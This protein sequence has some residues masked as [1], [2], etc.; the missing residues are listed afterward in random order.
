MFVFTPTEWSSRVFWHQAMRQTLT[1]SAR[2]V[3]Y[4]VLRLRRG[5][6]TGRY[7]F[8]FFTFLLSGLMHVC[9]DMAAGIP[10]AVSGVVQFF[11]IQALGIM[12]EDAVQHMWGRAS[13]SSG[14]SHDGKRKGAKGEDG[15]ELWKRVVGYVWVAVWMAWSVPVWSY[16]AA[17]RSSG[18]GVLPMSLIEHFR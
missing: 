2:F 5:G 17:R 15:P 9:G 10:F 16:P 8:T 11:A 12:I 1:S 7:T 4:S 14:S 6:V 3:T 18:E 13:Q